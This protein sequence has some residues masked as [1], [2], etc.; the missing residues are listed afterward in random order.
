MDFT[1][2]YN[3]KKLI[4]IKAKGTGIDMYIPPRYTYH[5]KNNEYEPYSIKILRK[6]IK[7]NKFFIDI[8]SHVG[9]YSL[10]ANNQDKKCKIICVEPVPY[11]YKV[12]IRN[13]KLNNVKAITYNVAISDR[14]LNNSYFY[15]SEASDSGGLTSHP[16]AKTIN[17]IKIKTRTI[18]EISK[19]LPV[20]LIKIDTEGNELK[21][22]QGMTQTIKNNPNMC[23]LFE[24]NLTCLKKTIKDPRL[25]INYI[26]SLGYKINFINEEN[27]QISTVENMSEIENIIKT[28]VRYM[29][30]LCIPKQQKGLI[31]LP[32]LSFN[33]FR[34]I[35][36]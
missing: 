10:L 9:Y 26:L 30:A 12:L 11:N 21:V 5:Y 23:I 16:R 7:P 4:R 18:D 28:Y 13:L 20:S 33:M 29:N 17:K 3:L 6:Y 32:K 36:Y 31:F 24:F 34:N 35:S 8:G 14:N 15:I 1:N 27:G 22:F 19:Y 2:E 25:L